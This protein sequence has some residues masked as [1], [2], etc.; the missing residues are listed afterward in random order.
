MI[1]KKENNLITFNLINHSI[2][3][4]ILLASFLW[5][6]LKKLIKMLKGAYHNSMPW[7]AVL[8]QCFLHQCNVFSFKNTI[9]KDAKIQYILIS[10]IIKH[11]LIEMKWSNCIPI[12]LNLIIMGFKEL[13]RIIKQII[14]GYQRCQ[15]IK[16]TMIRKI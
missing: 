9:Y 2:L 4:F 14:S 10:N 12:Y 16:T 7:T 8:M 11:N 5:K 6:M 3:T 15:N 13:L 1:Y